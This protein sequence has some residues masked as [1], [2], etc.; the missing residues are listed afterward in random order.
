ML[1]IYV[2]YV[3]FSTIQDPWRSAFSSGTKHG[4]LNLEKR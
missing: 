1:Q 2:E 4:K 3:Q